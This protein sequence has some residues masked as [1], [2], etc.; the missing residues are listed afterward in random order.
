MDVRDVVL[1]FSGRPRLRD[2]VTLLDVCASLDVQRA[3]VGQRSLVAVTGGNRHGQAMRR[4]LAGERHLPTRRR[5]HRIRAA[6]GYV[7]S[8]V[9]PA[10]VLVVGDRELA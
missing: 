5:T 8:A 7:Y 3:E 4:N 10:F 9:L 2:H 6:E 1:P